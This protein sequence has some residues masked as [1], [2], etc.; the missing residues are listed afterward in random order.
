VYTPVVPVIVLS[1][2]SVR[3]DGRGTEEPSRRS[4]ITFS[5]AESPQSAQLYLGAMR[6]FNTTLTELLNDRR[7]ALSAELLGVT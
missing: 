5:T 4:A 6:N 1:P 7:R 2:T 3:P